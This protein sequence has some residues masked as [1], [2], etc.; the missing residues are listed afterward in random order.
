MDG[1]DGF[2]VGQ[3]R[4]AVFLLQQIDGDQSGLPVVAVDDVRG[5]VQ[6]ARGLDDGAG[7]VSEPL[8]VVEVAVDLPAL[9]V[10]LVVHEPVG[11]AV[12]LQLEDAAVDLTPGQGD[13]EILQEGH[14]AAP[15]LA[16]SLIQGEDDLDLV[17]FLGQSLG[18]RAGHIGQT[19][20]LDKGSD[21]GRSK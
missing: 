16:D 19:A 9:E 21:L 17:A 12:A 5:P 15:F 4:D 11:D 20:G 7:E 3:L 6:L 18:Q 10:I 14:L 13:V 2:G 8:A 1:E